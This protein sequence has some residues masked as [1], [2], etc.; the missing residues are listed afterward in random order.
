[1]L[2]APLHVTSWTV[3]ES[4]CGPRRRS[5]AQNVETDARASTVAT[6]GL[7]AAILWGAASGPWLLG[8]PLFVVIRI[9]PR[10]LRYETRRK[11]QLPSD[12]VVGRALS[13]S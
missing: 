8:R 6:S 3:S 7:G 2:R 5:T 10:P 4:A 12:R 9:E 13:S 1:M 11:Q